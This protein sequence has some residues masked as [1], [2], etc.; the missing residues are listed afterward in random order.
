MPLAIGFL[1]M[2]RYKTGELSRR[3]PPEPMPLPYRCADCRDCF[4]TLASLHGHQT[5]RY[6]TCGE[7]APILE[8][9]TRDEHDDDRR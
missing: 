8:E 7:S 4:A 9:P 3:W 5:S 2:I 6:T 1:F